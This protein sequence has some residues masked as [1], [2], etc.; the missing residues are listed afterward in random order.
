MDIKDHERVVIELLASDYLST[1]VM[2][3][4]A[5]NPDITDYDV[6]GNGYFLTIRHDNLPL[7]RITCDQPNLMGKSQGIESGFLVFLG[8]HELVI[9]CFGYGSKDVPE[10]YRNMK[11][12][13]SVK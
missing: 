11:I 6:T 4:I 5:K 13:I 2:E 10:D 8:Q 7:E 3:E 1:E 12:D 9:E